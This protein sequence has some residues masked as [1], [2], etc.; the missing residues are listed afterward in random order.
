MIPLTYISG[1]KHGPFSQRWAFRALFEKRKWIVAD[2]GIDL[3]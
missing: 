2:L 3:L 1:N